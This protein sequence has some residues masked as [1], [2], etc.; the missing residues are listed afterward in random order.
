[1]SEDKMLASWFAGEQQRHVDE[2][3]AEVEETQDKMLWAKTQSMTVM[4][5]GEL[6][7]ISYIGAPIATCVITIKVDDEEREPKPEEAISVEERKAGEDVLSRDAW[8]RGPGRRVYYRYARHLRRGRICAAPRE[9]PSPA[10]SCRDCRSWNGTTHTEHDCA[11]GAY[12]GMIAEPERGCEGWAARPVEEKKEDPYEE[13]RSTALG[14]PPLLNWDRW[15]TY[16]LHQEVLEDNARL[17]CRSQP[18]AEGWFAAEFE[19]VERG[20]TTWTEVARK[21]GRKES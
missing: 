8:D 20:E 17:W 2:K 21:H 13:S 19:L 5:S 10:R 4:R 3:Q 6:G 15:E 7:L 18:R 11:H 1:M 12:G 14:A 9:E 16:L